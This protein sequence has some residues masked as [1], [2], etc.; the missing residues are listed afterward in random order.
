MTRCRIISSSTVG[1]A[2]ASGDAREL[3]V[4]A[5]DSFTTARHVHW[6]LELVPKPWRYREE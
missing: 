5:L 1:G 4:E 6:N 2:R 3:G